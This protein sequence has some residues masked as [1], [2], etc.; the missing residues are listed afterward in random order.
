M[1]RKQS[2]HLGD[3]WAGR[4]EADD[5]H[6][7]LRGDPF[8]SHFEPVLGEDTGLIVDF[9]LGSQYRKYGTTIEET[10]TRAILLRHASLLKEK[11]G[12]GEVERGIRMAL[13]VS[14]YPFSFK[15]VEKL[16]LE[17]FNE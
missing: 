16:I 5:T 1:D 17:R 8:S 4:P 11:Y 10:L 12:A 13:Q 7:I 3:Q 15:L 9:M 6:A 2:Q 14:R